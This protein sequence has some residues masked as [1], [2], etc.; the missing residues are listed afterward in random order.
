MLDSN[1]DT[2]EQPLAPIQKPIKPFKWTGQRIE[3][4]KHIAECALS[5][6]KISRLIG[7]KCTDTLYDWEK[8]PEF[9]AR[10][11]MLRRTW[12]ARVMNQGIANKARRMEILAKLNEKQLQIVEERGERLGATIANGPLAGSPAIAGGA[13]GLI[14]IEKRMTGYGE[15]AEMVDDEVFDAALSREVRATLAQ[16]AE[17]TGQAVSKHELTGKDG[18][19]ISMTVGVIDGI[20]ERVRAARKKHEADGGAGGGEPPSESAG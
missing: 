14:V 8:H 9:S 12:E 18:G 13:T 15:A 20:A 3:A 7:L 19:P 4:S 17:E 16:A 5:Y 6:V 10:I 2:N 1:S 11:S